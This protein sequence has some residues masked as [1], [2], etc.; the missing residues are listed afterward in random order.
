MLLVLFYHLDINFF[1]FG[2]I[3]VD[4]FFIISGFLM[5]IILPKYNALGFITARVQRL[6]PAM[7]VVISVSL[8]LGYFLQMPGELISN[9]KSSILSLFF[10]SQFFFLF[11]TGYFDIEAIYQP[12]LHTW[13]LG[14]EFLAY[15]IVFLFFI[16]F[17]REKL[18]S[19][20]LLNTFVCAAY[21]IYALTFSNINYLD[22]IPRLFLFFIGFYVSSK[23]SSINAPD[24][25]LLL[26]S[27]TSFLLIQ[28][29]FGV[30]ILSRAWPNFSMLLLPLAILPLLLLKVNLVKNK[31]LKNILVYTGNWS[32]SIYLWHWVIIAFERVYFRNDFINVPEAFLLFFMSFFLGIFSYYYLEKN[33]YI[34]KVFS[35]PILLFACFIIFTDGASYR[36]PTGLFK[37]SS[38]KLMINFDQYTSEKSISGLTIKTIREPVNGLETRTIIV[39]DSHSHHIIPFY[40]LFDTGPIYRLNM[41]PKELN[42][43]WENLL[44][45]IKELNINRVLISYR[46]SAKDISEIK[47]LV[48]N[49]NINLKRNLDL[50]LLRDIPSFSGDPVACLFANN[51]SLLFKPCGFDIEAGLP[52]NKVANRVNQQWNWITQNLNYPNAILIDTHSVF[53]NLNTCTMQVNGEFI[54]RDN[55]HFNEKMER[56]TR[57]EISNMIF[58]VDR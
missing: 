11:N 37:Y 55:N 9:S 34:S 45:V 15:V 39:G 31:F 27:F 1:K 40:K 22:P 58:E 47:E 38:D 3:G 29:F 18:E 57:Q 19:I 26:V 23:R 36:V 48:E 30:K 42:N 20:A 56:A 6:Y 50:I 35:L 2:Y 49:I 33:K 5:P 10:S 17:K 53:C 8:L 24:K 21:I 43:E 16:F 46:L 54:M 32:Y 44:I 52:L 12:L 14:N 7:V 28:H 51:S 25:L 13:S 4:I 41:Q